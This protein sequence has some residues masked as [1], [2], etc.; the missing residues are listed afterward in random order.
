MTLSLVQH[1]GGTTASNTITLT[2][3]ATG[4]GNA[5]II[6]ATYDSATDTD[7]QGVTLG[8]SGA[9]WASQLYV[10]ATDTEDAS[11][12]ANFSIAGGQ[13][14]LVVTVPSGDTVSALAVD[15]YE[16]SGGLVAL[17]KTVH[18]EVDGTSGSWTSTA[19]A[20]TSSASEFILGVVTGFNNADTNFAFTG[21]SSPWVNETQLNL[22]TGAS[23]M[24]GY[25]IAA[26]EAAF[27]YSGTA[28]TTGSNLY[29]LA[30]VAT[31][32]ASTASSGPVFHP[33]N[34]AVQAKRQ[35]QPQRGRI[36][37]SPGGPPSTHVI[38][39]SGK[40]SFRFGLQGHTP[41][42]S[43]GLLVTTQALLLLDA[44]L[45]QQ[46]AGSIDTLSLRLGASPPTATTPMGELPGGAGYT[47]G[48]T[49]CTFSAA[50]GGAAVNSTAL[51]W[52]NSG[53]LWEIYGLELWDPS[54]LGIP[55][56]WLFAD[57][58]GYPVAVA[59]GNT[60]AIPSS[61]LSIELA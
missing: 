7:L 27:T 2:L 38:S 10:N 37:S 15:A 35:R 1:A 40:I 22:L 44:I 21:P 59:T 32:R 28:N 57:W 50:S 46:P 9:G 36:R 14:S 23:S 56:R 20:T 51:S 6:V 29:Y 31:F 39:T 52:T 18:H 5:L 26:S 54:G 13:T 17:D 43:F 48:G 30:A 33:R 45:L 19:T 16:V 24:S 8:G 58:S 47:L 25:Q 34:S 41:T 61:S 60:F 3:S 4:A 12:W 42:F 49:P 55:V 53:A 11:I